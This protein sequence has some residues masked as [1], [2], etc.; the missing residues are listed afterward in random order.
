MI[1]ATR[2]GNANKPIDIDGWLSTIDIPFPYQSLVRH[3]SAIHSIIYTRRAPSP[4]H[5]GK[6]I[7]H[8][9]WQSS[10][11]WWTRRWDDEDEHAHVGFIDD[12]GRRELIRYWLVGR[13]REQ[14]P[15]EIIKASSSG[16]HRTSSPNLAHYRSILTNAE[17]LIG[18]WRADSLTAEYEIQLKLRLTC[19][20][21][22][23]GRCTS[24]PFRSD[25]ALQG[26][27]H[28]LMHRKRLTAICWV[29]DDDIH[30][31]LCK[32]VNQKI[33]VSALSRSTQTIRLYRRCRSW[34]A[35][36]S[37]RKFLLLRSINHGKD[38]NSTEKCK[39]SF[40]S[41][42]ISWSEDA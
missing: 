18:P 28:K 35:F 29:L 39:K 11:E 24:S 12:D 9:S 15:K 13:W 21:R 40:E 34:K 27:S 16:G 25:K 41:E 6:L 36:I 4:T 5:I 19:D 42:H 7:I 26:R 2:T 8:T 31:A 22:V 17:W 33:V 14:K 3:K 38:N 1:L 23:A 20:G 10:F 32:R 30:F 37:V